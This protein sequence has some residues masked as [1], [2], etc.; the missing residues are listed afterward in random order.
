MFAWRGSIKGCLMLPRITIITPSFNQ[1]QYL[2]QT[3]LSIL[4]QEYSNLEYIIVDGGSSDQSIQI[5]KKYQ[6]RLHYWLS[7]KDSGQS[8]AINKGF[9]RATGDIITWINSDDQLLPGTLQRV[10]EIFLANPAMTVVHGKT[11]LFGSGMRDTVR[12]ADGGTL[13]YSYL[14]GM[15]FPQPSCFFKK[16]LIDKVGMLN[17][18]LHYGMDYDFFVRLYLQTDFASVE[19]TFSK[20]LFHKN[21]KSTMAQKKFAAEW[22]I[23]FSKLMRTL[24]GGERIIT[25]LR[26]LNCYHEENDTYPFTRKFKT[27]FLEQ[28]FYHFI[29]NQIIF[30]YQSAM[31]SE[32][33]KLTRYLKIN[34]PSFLKEHN[35]ETVYWRARILPRALLI[36]LRKL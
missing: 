2:E 35:L 33:R 9:S 12:G 14:A 20:Y 34:A 23:V 25:E 24:P 28:S 3:I 27:D 30:Y 22:A 10:A 6:H 32:V 5:I 36:A 31:I 29:R 16:K 18:D 21:S 13:P 17:Q 7:E 4:S 15:A 8:E 26:L 11:I 19:D 1:A